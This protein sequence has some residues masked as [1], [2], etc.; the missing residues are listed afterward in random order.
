M[1][2][3]IRK[4]TPF[5]NGDDLE[6]LESYISFPVYMGCTNEPQKEDLMEDMN[7]YIDRS[8]GF[9]QLSP[10]LPLEVVYARGH[11]SG[12]V[13]KLWNDHHFEFCEFISQFKPKTVLEI[14]GLHGVLASNYF[15][16]FPNVNWTMIEP[17]PCAPDNLGI[18]IINGFFDESFEKTQDYDAIIHSHVLEHIYDLNSFM[19]QKSLVLNEGGLLLFSIPNMQEMLQRKYTNCL[20]FEHTFWL[21]EPYV[22]NLLSK[23]KLRL[24]KKQY[25]KDDHSIFYAAVK[26][27]AVKETA[28]N[29]NL[30]IKNKE[31]FNSFVHFMRSEVASLNNLI[32]DIHTPVY[33]FGGHIF[34]QYLVNFGLTEE[35][36][37]N[38]LDNDPNKE[39]GRLYGT[40]LICHS[41][42]I[43]SGLEKATIIL[44]AGI[45]NEE[46]KKDITLNINPNID[47]I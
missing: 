30:Y 32:S 33:L 4:E 35:F 45:Y 7:W 41:P 34:S 44:R 36:I 38:I 21:T 17:N 11:G 37:T 9:I 16:K 10:L 2:Y 42:K 22:E 19:T 6:P 14:G 46:I 47:F 24:I 25:F 27:S 15:K 8:S 20:N 28:L 39:G 12:T 13:G 18:K 23:F 26:D 3:L 31:T 1:N 29:K 40:N 43:L 5:S